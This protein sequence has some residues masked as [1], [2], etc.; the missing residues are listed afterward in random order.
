MISK[1]YLLLAITLL[2]MVVSPAMG[3]SIVSARSG[4]I[5]HIDGEVQID[6]DT[7]ESKF[8]EFPNLRNGSILTTELGRAEMLLTPGV[9]I[10]VA[11]QGA[12]KMISSRLTD[13]RL[14]VVEGSAL[15]EAMEILKENAITV[16]HNGASIQILKKGLYRI[17]SEPAQL[18]VYDGK[19]QVTRGD[20]TLVAKKGKVVELGAFLVATK[21][22]AKT[23]DPLHRWSARRSSYLAAANLSSA[24]SVD[25]WGMPWRASGWRWNPYFGMFT[26]VPLSGVYRSPFGYR[27]YSPGQVYVAYVPPRRPQPTGF[28]SSRS[29]MGGSYNSS[30]GYNTVT[31]RSSSSASSSSVSSS[32]TGAS[33]SSGASS[34]RGGGGGRG[35]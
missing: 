32:S 23:G 29:R 16:F 7:V 33:R 3:Q 35:R 11:E 27:Y 14:E 31:S 5:H 6:G 10:R 26:Y 9:I 4:A 24:R 19:A 34:G 8:A 28:A 20:D 22:D 1:R 13:T 2:A 17:D 12:V 25:Q 21:F 18:R 15:I 30:L